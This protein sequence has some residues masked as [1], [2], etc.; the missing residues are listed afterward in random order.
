IDWAQ[1]QEF[2]DAGHTVAECREWF[3]F[4]AGAW[5]RARRRG[6]LRPR[7]R[8]G[9]NRQHR[10]RAEVERLLDE[11]RRNSEVAATLGISSATV[12]Y[13]ARC[14]G[15][16]PDLRF[17]KRVDWAAVQKAH[18]EG[19][20]V[21]ECARR[22][23]FHKGSWHK[24]VQR[25]DIRPR[26]HLIPLDDLLVRGRSTNRGHLKQRL[27]AAGLKQDRCE[28]C[29]I[30][31]WLDMPLSLHVH[32][33]NGDGTDNRLENLQFLCPNCHSQ[34]DTYGGRNGHRRPERHLKLVEPPPEEDSEEPTGT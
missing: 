3:G 34:T 24:A 11:G 7:S 4:S 6:E 30:G 21:R 32:H 9:W 28:E 16:P 2:Y 23:G 29:G 33:R 8:G 15:V 13:H 27:I 22:F 1:V 20:S 14:L 5:D 19:T 12:S 25:G 31:D 17:A 26:S 10:T 18:D